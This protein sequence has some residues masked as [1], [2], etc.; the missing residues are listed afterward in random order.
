MSDPDLPSSSPSPSR[1]PWHSSPPSPAPSLWSGLG[2]TFHITVAVLGV[3]IVVMVVFLAASTGGNQSEEE[4]AASRSL[5]DPSSAPEADM[6]GPDDRPLFPGLVRDRYPDVFGHFTDAQLMDRAETICRTFGEGVPLSIMVTSPNPREMEA[7]IFA[8]GA[9][10]FA[11]C[12]EYMDQ[13]DRESASL[14]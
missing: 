3:A 2:R 6:V 7:L 1:T 10:V 11:F 5:P 13:W 4:P 14:W 12:P 8:T 9:A